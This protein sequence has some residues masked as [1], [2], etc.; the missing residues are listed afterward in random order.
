MPWSV[1]PW[2]KLLIAA[3]MVCSICVAGW[4]GYE[5]GY[6][7]RDLE[8][9]AQILAA[10]QQARATERRWN[11]KLQE[12]RTNASKRETDLRRAVDSARAVVGSLRDQLA[13]ATSRLP[14][15]TC[16]ASREYATTINELF[17]QCAQAY[18]GMA[19][20]AD[21]HANDA[22]MLQEAWPK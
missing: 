13:A 8:A 14:S 22:L 12:A 1:I 5:T 10:E 16:D 18:Q 4:R 7:R 3:A 6:Q 21:R 17:G 15:A 11:L 19:E 20:Q 2:T 9:K